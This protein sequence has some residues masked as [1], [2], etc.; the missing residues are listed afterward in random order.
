[1]AT[2][3]TLELLLWVV[4]LLAGCEGDKE[5]APPGDTGEEALDPNEFPPYG[6]C[7]LEEESYWEGEEGPTTSTS[8]YDEDENL[9]HQTDVGLASAWDVVYTYEDDC[10]ASFYQVIDYGGPRL[11]YEMSYACDEHGNTS[12][13]SGTLSFYSDAEE[14]PETSPVTVTMELLYDDDL[15]VAWS[16]RVVQSD[17]VAGLSLSG[18]SGRT[19]EYEDGLSVKRES[20]ADF[21]RTELETTERWTYDDD[22][23]VQTYM[24]DDAETDLSTTYSY[25]RDTW[26][27]VTSYEGVWSTGLLFS[28]SRTWA[29]DAYRALSEG[30]DLGSD[31]ELDEAVT[32]TWQ[33]PVW[34]WRY[35][36]EQDGL[37]LF[38]TDGTTELLHV[39]DGERDNLT[40]V[41]WTC[42]D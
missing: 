13:G 28:F 30:V 4:V 20:F 22:G 35:S 31:G 41:E 37:I 32:W 9:V 36:T 7:T 8:V 39:L 15:L 25:T 23:N 19:V 6:G 27:R 33:E 26:G 16:R 42:P 3:G 11:E 34:P 29:D 14:A 10:L 1:M 18:E 40:E 21:E 38:Y 24:I 5:S 2:I 17:Y 12:E